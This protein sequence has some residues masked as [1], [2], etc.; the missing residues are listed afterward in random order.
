MAIISSLDQ[1]LDMGLRRRINYKWRLFF[2]LVSLLWLTIAAMVAIQYDREKAY[3]NDISRQQLEFINKRV[4]SAYEHGIDIA[5]FLGFVENYFDQSVYEAVRVSVYDLSTN[6]LISSIGEPIKMNKTDADRRPNFFYAHQTSKD[7]KLAVYTA[8]PY[9]VSLIEALAPDGTMWIIIIIFALITSA[10]AFISASYLSKNVNLLHKFAKQAATETSLDANYRFPR[11]ELGE[12]SQQIVDLF[13]SKVKAVE[14]REK[15]QQKALEAIKEKSRI[16]RELTNNINHE[17]KTPVGIIKGYIDTIA[18]DPEMPNNTRNH[19]ITKTQDQVNRLCNL[20][21]DISTITRLSDGNAEIVIEPVNFYKLVANLANEV[22]E[23]GLI[24]EMKFSF[25]LPSKC[26]VNGNSSL[27]NSSILNLIKNAVAYSRGTEMRLELIEENDK[28]YTFAFYDNGLGVDDE[29]LPY[30]FD[31]FYRIDT[32]RSRKVGGTG[33]GLPIVK[34]TIRTFGGKI[35]VSNRPQG[36]LEF[37][38]SLP[39]AN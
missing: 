5:P 38:F 31:R 16:K 8:M 4:V 32:G 27:L 33:L 15:E 13:N 14:E 29:H 22:K 7:S 30:L 18:D 34:N 10:I 9:T 21:N 20:L 12:V 19:F 2:P 1:V 24:K 35:T 11:D 37:R 23:S 39:R 6:K 36:G 26:F 28:F 3:R 25:G 17:L